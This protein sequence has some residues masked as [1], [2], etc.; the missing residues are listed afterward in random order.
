MRKTIIMLA[1][2]LLMAGYKV[3]LPVEQ[4]SGKE[5]RAYLLFV[6]PNE[7][8]GKDVQ[9]TIDGGKSFTARVVK[10]KKSARHGTQYGIETGTRTV[11][12]SHGDKT[13]YRKKIVVSTQEVK[14]ITL[15]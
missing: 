13:L 4:Q 9:V 11:T 3:N 14:Q 8:A 5:D 12:V 10:G 2:P 7:Y 15:P 1:L 6:S